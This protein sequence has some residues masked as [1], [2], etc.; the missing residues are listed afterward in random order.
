MKIVNVKSAFECRGLKGVSL[1]VC[2]WFGN[3]YIKVKNM[4]NKKHILQLKTKYDIREELV[5]PEWA[6]DMCL[7]DGHQFAEVHDREWLQWN[8][9]HNLSGK[10]EDKQHFWAIYRDGL[11]VGFIFTKERL[12]DDVTSNT[13]CGTLCEW[14]TIDSELKEDDI[15]L[16]AVDTFPDTCYY[17][18]TVT[19]D[20]HVAKQLLQMG[21]RHHGSM[22]MGIKDKYNR[23]PEMKN[24]ELWRL[25]FGCCNSILY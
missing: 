25:R 23:Y 20:S 16:L 5:V 12:R 15:N 3:L 7:N 18:R 13:I 9:T 10:A 22:Q 24:R 2:T 4:H 6:A 8:L 11:P 19:D 14:A 17:V 1:R 21:Y